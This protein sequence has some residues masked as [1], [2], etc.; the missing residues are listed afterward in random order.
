MVV[1]TSHLT[2]DKDT[3][4]LVASRSLSCF[5]APAFIKNKNKFNLLFNWPK[6]F[7]TVLVPGF[8]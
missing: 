7:Q 8:T 6:S 1:V 5:M 3:T 2:P 4:W